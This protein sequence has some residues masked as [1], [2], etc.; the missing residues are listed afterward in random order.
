MEVK[1]DQWLWL[2]LHKKSRQVLTRQVGPRD[3]KTTELLFAKLPE[4]LKKPYFTDKFNVYYET[5][6]WSQHHPVSKQS[7]Q[8][9]DIERFN[10]TLRQRCSRLVRKTLSFL[11][12][13]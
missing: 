8:T 13:C 7:G 10:C 5:I 2:V 1:N 11:R 3:K 12:A 6:L 4:S 9:S